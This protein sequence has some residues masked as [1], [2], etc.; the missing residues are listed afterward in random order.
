VTRVL[1]IAHSAHEGGA[2]HCLNTMLRHLDRSRFSATIVFACDGPMADAA[3]EMGY[4]VRLL[5]L[6]WW[7]FVDANRWYFKNLLGSWRRVRQLARSIREEKVDIVYTNTAVVFEAAAAARR[8]GVPHVW[9]VH[10]VLQP[11]SGLRPL[12]PIRWIQ[13]FIRRRS[14]HVVFESDAAR[15]VFESAVPLTRASVVPNSLRFGRGDAPPSKR[16]AR[17]ALGLP[18]DRWIVGFVGQMIDRKNPLLLVEAF[19]RL[20]G[21]DD[22]HLLMAGDGPLREQVDA[23]IRA[24]GLRERSTLLPFQRDVATT[25]AAMD[26]LALPSRQESFGLVLVEAAA[27]GK[28]VVACRSQGPEEIVD[29]CVTGLLVPQDDP[30]A[31][32]GALARLHESPETGDELGA[33]ARKSVFERFDPATNTRAIERILEEAI[34]S[35]ASTSSP[36]P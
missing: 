28:P 5:P 29:D 13:R 6:S 33:A 22:A 23:R 12:A 31:L 17:Q 3:R 27:L 30:T 10:E 36:R 26:V 4:E 34:A 35:V 18:Q 21:A 16:D 14:T 25:M 20:P 11:C 7:L 32:A 9:H 15:R 1:V 24:L 8:A 2:E 19:A